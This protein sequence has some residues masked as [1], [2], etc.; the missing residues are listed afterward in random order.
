MTFANPGPFSGTI[1]LDRLEFAPVPEPSTY[2]LLLA[3]GLLALV[4][5]K[6]ARRNAS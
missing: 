6:W 1:F 4:A 5:R 2:A 3:A